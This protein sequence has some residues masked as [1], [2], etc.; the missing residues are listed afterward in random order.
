M[1]A[2]TLYSGAYGPAGYFP[3][4]NRAQR[5][6]F[7]A[8]KTGKTSYRE[9]S[10]LIGKSHSYIQQF[11]ERGTPRRLSD[12]YR[13][14][15][16]ARL[17]VDETELLAED[18]PVTVR[19]GASRRIIDPNATVAGTVEIDATVPLYGQ[20]VSGKDGRFVWNGEKIRDVLAPPHLARIPNAYAVGVVGDSMEPR[21]YAGEVVFVNPHKAA[22]RG[23][24]VVV[25]IRAKE[26]SAPDAYIKQFVSMDDR[27]LVLEQFNPRKRLAFKRSDV[28]SVHRIVMGGDG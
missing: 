24:F 2:E 27:K 19:A 22:R 7:E 14:K 3:A 18:D 17:G 8:V 1:Q 26:D 5:T 21:Y 16:A 28:V 13:E 6:I 25:Q 4:M 23:D 11:V 15:I 10:L 12:I 9:L 20:A